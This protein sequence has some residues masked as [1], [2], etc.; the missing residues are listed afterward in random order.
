[1]NNHSLGAGASSDPAFSNKQPIRKE[2]QMRNVSGWTA[3]VLAFGLLAAAAGIG[4]T[5]DTGGNQESDSGGQRDSNS[6]GNEQESADLPRPVVNTHVLMERFHEDYYEALQAAVTEEPADAPEWKVIEHNAVRV[7][8]AANLVAIR[9][10]E[11]TNRPAWIKLT[12]ANQQ[13]A[14][15][16]YEAAQARNF[17]DVGQAYAR[18]IESCNACHKQMAADEAPVLEP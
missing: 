13:A 4:C 7:A 5:D 18:V 8:E 15:A 16:L 10:V 17:D 12:R 1:M 2:K 9:E 11:E 6:G 14:V 3:R